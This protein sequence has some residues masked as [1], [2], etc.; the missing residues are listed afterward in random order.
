MSRHMTK[1]ALLTLMARE[2]QDLP[3]LL[4]D[5]G[6]QG[7]VTFLPAIGL[8]PTGFRITRLDWEIIALLVR[9]AEK[10]LD[11]IAEKLRV[12]TRTVKRR[13]NMMMRDAAIFTMPMVDL[14][15]MEGISYQLRVQSEPGKK[16]EVEKSVAAK[17]GEVIFRATDSQNG[18]IFGFNGANVAEGNDILEWA[19]Q[20]PGVKS[21]SLTIAE[22]VIQVFD[23][24]QDEISRQ[25][26]SKQVP[27]A[28]I[29]A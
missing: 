6:V 29:E 22:R 21:V 2:G 3:K 16:Q 27:A 14:K 23:W 4:R 26:E 17:I 12:S 25:V 9:D 18:S 13:L 15:K 1:N 28:G 20:E 8:R 10:K 19:K 24:V 5:M 7:E 11:E